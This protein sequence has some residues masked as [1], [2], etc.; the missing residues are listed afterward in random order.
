MSRIAIGSL[1]TQRDQDTSFTSTQNDRLDF[2][3]LTY[4]EKAIYFH[5]FSNTKFHSIQLFFF[6]LQSCQKGNSGLESDLF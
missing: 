4:Q 6:T 2:F 5:L 1:M 3:P